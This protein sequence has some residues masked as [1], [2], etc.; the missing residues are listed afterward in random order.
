MA[1]PS[2]MRVVAS[3]RSSYLAFILNDASPKTCAIANPPEPE[4]VRG[5]QHEW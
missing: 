4:G 5:L 1:P 2:A 3:G